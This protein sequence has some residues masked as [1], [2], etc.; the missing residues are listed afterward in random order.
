[1]R[2]CIGIFLLSLIFQ[3]GSNAQSPRL[4]AGRVADHWLGLHNN[5]EQTSDV[6]GNY[7]LDLTLEALLHLDPYVEETSYESIVTDVFQ[8]RQVAPADTINYRSQPFCSINF[9]LGE[10]TGDKSWHRGFVSESYRMLDEAVKSPE[11]GIMHL[12]QGEHRVLIDY[13]QEY[14]SRLAKTGYLTNDTALFRESVNQFLIYEKIVRDD[15][16]GLWRQGRGWCSDTTKLSQGAWSRGQGWLLRGMVTSMRYL[17]QSYQQQLLPTLERLT[18]A[19]LKVQVEDGMYHIL[20]DLPEDES[21]PDVSGTG[22]IAYYMSVAVKHGWLEPGVFRPSILK[23]T[24]AMKK[25]I[26]E[27]GRILSSSK[28]P[29]PLCSQ[30][31]Y[32]GYTPEIDEKHG[33]QGAI[34]GMIAEMMMEGK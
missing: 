8:K 24:E 17:P 12:H 25:Y 5:F 11:G 10:V 28:G 18:H 27:D 9:M 19:L 26:A 3:S 15:A 4:V 13:L 14:A 31:E 32:I 20:L 6:W 16:T 1:M 29:G 30:E 21:A 34:Y 7:T 23:A 22:M 33:F 2:I